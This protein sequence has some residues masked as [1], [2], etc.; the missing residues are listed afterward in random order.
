MTGDEGSANDG[1]NRQ[2]ASTLAGIETMMQEEIVC[3]VEAINYI[4]SRLDVDRTLRKP[5]LEKQLYL[6]TWIGYR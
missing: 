3:A 2:Y 6:L 4:C 1:S 5:T